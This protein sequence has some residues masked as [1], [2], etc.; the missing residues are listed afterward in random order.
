MARDKISACLT[1]GNEEKKIRRC[2]QSLTWADEIVVVDSFSTDRTVDICR[3]YTDRVYQHEWL[4]YVGQKN[5]IKGMAAYPW[6]LFI[7][8]DEEISPELRTNIINEF[9]SSN[10]KNY[11]GYEFPRRVF[12]LGKWIV[13]GDWWPDVKMRLYLKD[14]GICTGREPHEHVVVDGPVK[15]LRGCLNHY[16]YDDISDQVQTMNKFSTISSAGMVENA[17][18]FSNWDIFFRPFF[19]FFRG[20]VIKHGFI[21]GYRGLIIAVLSAVG[22]FLKYAKLWEQYNVERAKPS[23]KKRTV[24]DEGN[25]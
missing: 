5:L 20:Y 24:N 14:G 7:D 1:V 6:I 8:A 25:C 13:H 16:T 10:N 2:L 3:E 23:S 21:D 17:R 9:E 18:Q 11:A 12:F 19:R 22:V 15:R 4:G